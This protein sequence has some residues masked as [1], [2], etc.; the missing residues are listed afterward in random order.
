M[1]IRWLGAFGKS[2]SFSESLEWELSQKEK[3]AVAAEKL[4]KGKSF[5]SHARVGLLFK[6]RAIL[7]RYSSDVYSKYTDKGTLVT[8]RKEGVATSDHTECFVR[9][10]YCAIVVKGAVSKQVLRA[11]FESKMDVLRLT[12]DRRLVAL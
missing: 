10:D 2:N 3:S 5:I 11:C 9:P 1:I 6:N 7:R 4:A 12:R 8:T